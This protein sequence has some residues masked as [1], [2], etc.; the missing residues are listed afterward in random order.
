MTQRAVGL[1][2][3]SSELQKVTHAP[4]LNDALRVVGSAF[5]EPPSNGAEA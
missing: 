2:A 1:L 3:S 4:Q 5:A